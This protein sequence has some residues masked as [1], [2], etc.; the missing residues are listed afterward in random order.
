MVDIYTTWIGEYDVDGFRID[1]MKHVNDE[2]WQAFAPQVLE[3]AHEHGKD[4]FFMFGE[5]FDTSR[6]NF[7]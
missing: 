6:N 1:T 3:Y 5:V 2:F 7:V 4:D